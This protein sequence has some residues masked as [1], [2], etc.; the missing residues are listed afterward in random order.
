MSTNIY[1]IFT[2]Q[3]RLETNL[4]GIY[5][6]V[7]Y[8]DVTGQERKKCKLWTNFNGIRVLGQKYFCVRPIVRDRFA[9]TL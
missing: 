9:L 8:L 2:S 3:V 1:F 4:K 7:N 5:D 6:E